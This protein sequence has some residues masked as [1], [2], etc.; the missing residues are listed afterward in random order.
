M[1]SPTKEYCQTASKN[2]MKVKTRNQI[3]NQHHVRNVKPKT[4][5]KRDNI[6]HKQ[7]CMQCLA[8]HIFMCSS[9]YR[10]TGCKCLMYTENA[11]TILVIPQRLINI[12]SYCYVVLEKNVTKSFKYIQHITKFKVSQTRN[13]REFHI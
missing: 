13:V 4:I 6:Y 2:K 7:E 12:K 10:L 3:N 11:S 5:N 1:W 8:K 9:K